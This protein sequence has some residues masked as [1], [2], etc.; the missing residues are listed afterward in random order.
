MT[1]KVQP[2]LF[3]DSQAVKG[4]MNTLQGNGTTIDLTC[5]QLGL[6]QN[7]HVSSSDHNI[8]L[9]MSRAAV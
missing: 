3:C 4:T 7:G 5:D 1:F 6:K 8:T 9:K 2:K